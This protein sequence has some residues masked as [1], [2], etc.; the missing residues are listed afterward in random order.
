MSAETVPGIPPE[1]A[2][3][4]VEWLL[5]LQEKDTSPATRQA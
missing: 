3:R 4:A 1:V 2:A 5:L